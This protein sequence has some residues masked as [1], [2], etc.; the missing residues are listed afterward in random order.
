MIR[1]ILCWFGWHEM[2]E[3]KTWS[4]VLQGWQ[5]I[6]CRCKH[7]GYM[8]DSETIELTFSSNGNKERR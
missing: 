5:A 4:Q 7:C 3:F 8:Y 1:A 6:R 2:V